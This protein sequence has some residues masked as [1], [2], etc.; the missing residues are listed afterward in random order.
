MI[1]VALLSA[2][3]LHLLPQSVRRVFHFRRRAAVYESEWQKWRGQKDNVSRWTEKGRALADYASP[4]DSLVASAIG[5]V[6][7]YSDLFIHDRAG[8]V[9]R[10]VAVRQ[11]V[12][13]LQTSPGHDKMVEETF[14]LPRRPEL[15]RA[16]VVAGRP[17][18]RTVEMIEA[19]VDELREAGLQDSYV[20][21]FQLIDMAITSGKPKYFV[22]WRRIEEG[23]DPQTARDAFALQLESLEAGSPL[24]PLKSR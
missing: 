20:V 19:Q 21:D 9:T 12:G 2:W 15:L 8:L 16:T 7:Y 5:A 14:F 3:D 22:V 6:G 24:R 18:A 10:E 1:V 23:S 13:P 4:G 11:L 17:G